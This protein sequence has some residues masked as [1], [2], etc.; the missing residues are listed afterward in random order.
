M[1]SATSGRGIIAATKL[2]RKGGSA[3]GAVNGD[4]RIG[5]WLIE[6]T[7]NR[8]SRDG[9]SRHLEPKVMAV[10][11]C[12]TR[13]K[14]A[15]VSKQQLIDEV[16]QETFVTDDVLTRSISE[17]RRVFDDDAKESQVIQTIHRQGYRLIA[18]ITWTSPEQPQ[19]AAGQRQTGT[20]R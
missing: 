19:E 15:V 4:F 9:A 8:I 16:W 18:P 12:L 14:N 17:L 7:L 11:V 5:A 13:A 20:D 3:G 10:L 1:F 2:P 6:P